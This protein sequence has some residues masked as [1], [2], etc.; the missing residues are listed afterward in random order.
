MKMQTICFLFCTFYIA[1]FS[2]VLAKTCK[3]PIIILKQADHSS[4]AAM[5]EFGTMELLELQDQNF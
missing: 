1:A 2:R 3:I 5:F 4:T